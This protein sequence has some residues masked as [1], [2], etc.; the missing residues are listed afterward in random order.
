MKRRF[1]PPNA[2]PSRGQNKRATKADVGAFIEE[3]APKGAPRFKAVLHYL[4]I[5]V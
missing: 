1:A 2:K 4:Y 5:N 3:H